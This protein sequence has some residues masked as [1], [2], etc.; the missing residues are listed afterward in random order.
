MQIILLYPNINPEYY[1]DWVMVTQILWS[2]FRHNIQ[3]LTKLALILDIHVYLH[4]HVFFFQ[5]KLF[6]YSVLNLIQVESLSQLNHG[7]GKLIF[8][9]RDSF[10]FLP[11]EIPSAEKSRIETSGSAN[12]HQGAEVAHKDPMWVLSVWKGLGL[13]KRVGKLYFHWAHLEPFSIW[14]RA[15]ETVRTV[16]ISYEAQN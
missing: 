7:I 3:M 12:I 6:C 13:W 1:Y 10:I 14:G 4:M 2:E 11:V 5:S 8:R 15:V 16:A 9:L